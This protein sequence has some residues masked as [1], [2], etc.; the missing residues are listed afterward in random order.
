MNGRRGKLTE[1]DA[2][3][4]L[5]SAADLGSKGLSKEADLWWN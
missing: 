2:I 1:G 5:K 4:S 3:Y